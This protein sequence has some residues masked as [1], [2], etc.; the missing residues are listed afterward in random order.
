MLMEGSSHGERGRGV[1]VEKWWGAC[2]LYTQKGLCD[3]LETRMRH[4]GCVFLCWGCE[5]QGQRWK[6]LI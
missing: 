5:D 4:G 3:R 1:A 6:L 2:R